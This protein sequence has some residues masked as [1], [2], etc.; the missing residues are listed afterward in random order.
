MTTLFSSK[1]KPTIDIKLELLIEMLEHQ[2]LAIEK[3]TALIQELKADLEAK[4]AKIDALEAKNK[5]L[6]EQL[7][8]NSKNSSKP[9]SSDG[10]KKPSPK[11]LRQ[12][13]GKSPGAQ[14]G[15]KGAGLKLMSKEPDEI[16]RHFPK[17][18][19]DCPLFVVKRA[20]PPPHGDMKSTS[21]S[22]Q[23]WWPM[24]A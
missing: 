18:C 23:N 1:D 15:H 9:P 24:S 13:S 17:Q 5:A 7:G 10:L 22:T 8:M 11:S 20:A 21:S 3:Q 4:A 19:Q 2:T 12:P 14:K 6:M 16:V